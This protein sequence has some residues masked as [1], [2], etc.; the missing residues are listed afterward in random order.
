M[1][2]AG[3]LPDGVQTDIA[4]QDLTRVLLAS[5]TVSSLR[6]VDRMAARFVLAFS[7]L[8]GVLTGL[9]QI[10][11][12]AESGIVQEVALV[13]SAAPFPGGGRLADG[14]RGHGLLQVLIP[15]LAAIRIVP[16]LETKG[17]GY[18]T[19]LPVPVVAADILP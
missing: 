7:L 17:A 3:A 2:K 5:L 9:T 4:W 13:R 10:A 14:R 6:G 8:L 1:M 12:G 19:H 15:A 16:A 11:R 18:F